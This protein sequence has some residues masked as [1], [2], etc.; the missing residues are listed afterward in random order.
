MKKLIIIVSLLLMSMT[1]QAY[2]NIKTDVVNSVHVQSPRQYAYFVG[3]LIERKIFLNIDESYMLVEEELPKPASINYWLDL[4]DLHIESQLRDN[5]NEIEITLSY[6]AFYVPLSVTE[7]SIPTYQLVVTDGNESFRLTIPEWDFL[8]SP[9]K[10]IEQA[11]VGTSTSGGLKLLDDMSP[12]LVDT[13]DH[14]FRILFCIGLIFITII[15]Y[16]GTN[17]VLFSRKHKPFRN[18][19]RKIK[20]VNE[21]ELSEVEFIDICKSIH[22][23]FN[24][25]YGAILFSNNL[26]E[27]FRDR[28][29]FT[30]YQ[31]NITKFYAASSRLFYA[32][33]KKYDNQLMSL[34]ELRSMCRSLSHIESAKKESQVN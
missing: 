4:V 33:E 25:C 32:Q 6:Q 18:T 8:M 5:S 1:L 19:Y 26:Q 21:S 11:G 17:G 9:I 22:Q 15:Y 16:L 3:D 7:R 12:V 13:D 29:E 24:Q 34:G 30:P 31:D 14:K 23:S 10:P 2:N 20:S 27:L 28:Q